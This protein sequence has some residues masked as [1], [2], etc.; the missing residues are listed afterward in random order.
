M[1]GDFRRKSQASNVVYE[2]IDGKVK[3]QEI[4]V[5]EGVRPTVFDFSGRCKED[6]D[7]GVD[8]KCN[9]VLPDEKFYRTLLS[10]KALAKKQ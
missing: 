1:R 5:F 7:Y 9:D 4:L 10:T 6:D 2:V 3:R 8:A